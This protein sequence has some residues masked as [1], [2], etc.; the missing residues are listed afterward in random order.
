MD[1]LAHHFNLS[2][3]APKAVEYLGRAG[4]RTAKHG[5]H[6]EAV[7]YFM[8]AL[9]LLQ[10]LPYGTARDRRELDLQMALSCSAFVAKGHLGKLC[11][12]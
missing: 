10:Q 1:E 7:G 3:N 12:S 11:T 8:K 6:S 2:G 5:A 9:E 4:E